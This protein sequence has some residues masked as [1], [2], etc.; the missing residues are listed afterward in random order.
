MKENHTVLKDF[1]ERLNRRRAASRDQAGDVSFPPANVQN[2][3]EG[4]KEPDK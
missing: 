1:T 2:L 3:D 4:F